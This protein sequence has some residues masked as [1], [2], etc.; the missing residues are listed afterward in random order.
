MVYKKPEPNASGAP[1]PGRRASLD[2]NEAPCV[3]QLSVPADLAYPEAAWSVRAASRDGLLL[4]DF[5]DTRQ[6]PPAVRKLCHKSLLHEM[7]VSGDGAQLDIARFV[8]NPLTG[9]LF[10]IPAPDTDAGTPFGLLTQSPEASHGPPHRFV[11]AHLGR[12]EGDRSSRVV[13]RYLSD[14][15]EW[16]ERELLAP[17]TAPLAWRAMQIDTDHEVLALGDRLWWVDLSLG[18]C[19]VDPFSDRPEH[20]FVQLPDCTALPAAQ[21]GG[22]A[23]A[24]SP[25][26]SRYGRVGVSDGKLRYVQL[27]NTQQPFQIGSFS[28]DAETCSWTLDHAIKIAETS[29]DHIFNAPWIAAIDPFRA[30]VLYLQHGGVLELLLLP[31]TWLRGGDLEESSS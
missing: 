4:L 12:G 6:F 16:D 20:R 1:P 14:T 23:L 18:V 25:M 21:T 27:R 8:C 22:L 24:G 29:P 28:L 10:R 31:W 30:N 9:Q 17:S 2:L 7:A 13:R 19:S 26:L 5:A 11:V 3:S 15:G